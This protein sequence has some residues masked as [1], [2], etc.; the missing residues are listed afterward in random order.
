MLAVGGNLADNNQVE[1]FD[2]VTNTWTT[3]THFP[4]GSRLVQN[5]LLKNLVMGFGL[6]SNQRLG[7]TSMMVTDVEDGLY[8]G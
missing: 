4:F 1:S 5:E 8:L 7:A 2:I 6:K 3:K